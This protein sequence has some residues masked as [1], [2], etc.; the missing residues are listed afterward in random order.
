MDPEIAYHIDRLT[1]DYIAQGLDR[2]RP[3]GAH[4]SNSAARR[5]SKKT[6]AISGARGGS[7]TCAR[8]WSTPRAHCAAA[9]ASWPVRR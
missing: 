4:S 5:N 7:P 1:Q 3:G 2:A 8:I 9:G 6:C